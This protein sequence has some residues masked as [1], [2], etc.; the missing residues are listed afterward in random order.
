VSLRWLSGYRWWSV[1]RYRRKPLEKTAE[2]RFVEYVKDEGGATRK[3]NGLGYRSWPDQL[4]IKPGVKPGLWVEFKRV[5]EDPTPLQ[6][7]LHKLLRQLGQR[8]VVAWT[9]E[10]ARK[11]YDEHSA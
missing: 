11:A 5:G 3:M 8:V 6:K 9:F 10:Q 4:A 2:K 7:D 1:R